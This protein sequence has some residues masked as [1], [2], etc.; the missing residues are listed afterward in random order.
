MSGIQLECTCNRATIWKVSYAK[1]HIIEN[2][3]DFV[4]K[5]GTPEWKP[6]NSI[7]MLGRFISSFLFL[8][9][10]VERSKCYIR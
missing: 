1:G 5:P 8:G 9:W 3:I 4:T 6:R 7:Y 2:V 10:K